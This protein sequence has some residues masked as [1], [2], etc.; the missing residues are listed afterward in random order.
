MPSQ[1]SIHSGAPEL[2]F[3][4]NTQCQRTMDLGDG[5]ALPITACTG[6]QC[7]ARAARALMPGGVSQMKSNCSQLQKANY[8]LCLTLILLLLA[9]T[10]ANAMS[11]VAFITD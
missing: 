8:F 2:L 6:N 5:W 10:C 1:Y 4:S 7:K 11:L 9:I 3:S